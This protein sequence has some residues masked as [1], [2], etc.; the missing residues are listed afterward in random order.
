MSYRPDR[1]FGP[2]P[3]AP[4]AV[5]PAR[6]RQSECRTCGRRLVFVQMATGG[7][8][9]CDPVQVYGDGRRTLVVRDAQLV[10]HLVTAAGPDVFGLEPHWGTCPCR[11]RKVRIP[12]P[13]LFDEVQP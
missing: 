6:T 11:T 9:P 12:V 4:P 10:G 7:T 8:M 2:A 1:R 5:D 3:F 13:T